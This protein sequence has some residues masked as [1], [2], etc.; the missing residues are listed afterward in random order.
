MLPV[1]VSGDQVMI[2][3]FVEFLGMLC[4]FLMSEPI[5]YF[6]AIFLGACVLGLVSK[7]WHINKI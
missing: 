5:I 2:N 4:D 6:T 1:L 7:I 3:F